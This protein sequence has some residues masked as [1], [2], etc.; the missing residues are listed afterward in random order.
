MPGNDEVV[1]IRPNA[2]GAR[3]EGDVVLRGIS[4][5]RG[6]L[7]FRHASIAGMLDANG[8]AL[9]HPGGRTLNLHQA[10]VGGNVRLCA[11]FD[12]TGVVVLSRA[13]IEGRLRFD[14]ATLSWRADDTGELYEPNR[15]GSALEAISTTVRAG[16]GLGWRVRCGAVD[17]TD[18]RTTYLADDPAHDWPRVAH[19]SGFTY[20]RFA[21]GESQPGHGEWDAR[22]R[23]R[24]L[25]RLEPFDPQAWEQVGRVLHANGDHRGAEEVYLA[26]RRERRRRKIGFARRPWRLLFDAAQDHA[27]RY[28][29]R[30]QRALVALLLLVG[31][32]ALSLLPAT[33]QA[34][35]RAT[36]ENAVVYAPSGPLPAQADVL[37]GRCGGGRVRCFNP[38]LYAIDTVVPIIDLHQR[39]VWYPSPDRGGA[40][41]EWWLNL[42]TVLGWITSTVFALSFTRLGRSS[43]G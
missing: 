15:R 5:F 14:G 31:A 43:T 28:G 34:T 10:R 8:A 13:V 41:L 33:T 23:S 40:L 6:D 35:M 7:H 16:I 42:C 20:E 19:L 29:L 37:A 24:W 11:G 30:P 27:V 9:W 17:F 3:I 21:A 1:A 18:A 36:D 38:L 12:S 4:V 32:V 26:Q 22:V 2:V 25:A 39:S